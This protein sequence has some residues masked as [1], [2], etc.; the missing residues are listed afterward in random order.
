[1]NFD[2]EQIILDNTKHIKNRE[3]KEHSKMWL[4]AY[5]IISNETGIQL[6][7]T[8]NYSYCFVKKGKLFGKI[9]VY[10]RTDGYVDYFRFGRKPVGF[11]IGSEDIFC[12]KNPIMLL[13]EREKFFRLF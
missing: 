6:K 1:M 9:G 11:D 10:S 2:I 3:D 12:S 5:Y 7:D 8:V 13:E 4:R